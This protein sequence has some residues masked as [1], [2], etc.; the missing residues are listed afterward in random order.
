[1]FKT[2][3]LYIDTGNG[4]SL[5]DLIKVCT[6]VESESAESGERIGKSLLPFY[7][8]TIHKIVL[9]KLK[10]LLVLE[11]VLS[12]SDKDC[13]KYLKDLCIRSINFFSSKVI[14]TKQR[15]IISI[16][17]NKYLENTPIGGRENRSFDP[18]EIIEFGS[19]SKSVYFMLKDKVIFRLDGYIYIKTDK[20]DD[21]TIGVDIMNM[22]IKDKMDKKMEILE[23]E[24]ESNQYIKYIK[25]INNSILELNNKPTTYSGYVC[26]S[27]CEKSRFGLCT[28]QVTHPYK[29]NGITYDWDYCDKRECSK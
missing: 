7:A 20:S 2:N 10:D 28:C 6:L 5:S 25:E 22:Y 4:S 14:K 18:N 8:N 24:E 15:E 27:D 19:T 13:E 29:K 12:L 16:C 9:K 26:K 21:C 23:I 1:M 3:L 11:E 17:V